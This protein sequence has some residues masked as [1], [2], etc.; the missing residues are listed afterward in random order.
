MR[1]TWLTVSAA[2]AIIFG[3]RALG[4]EPRFSAG[5]KAARAGQ[6]A[7][8]SFVVSG[9]TDVEVAVLDAN[10]RIVRHLAA[11]VLGAKK[12]PPAPLVAGLSQAVLWDGKDDYGV[13]AKGAPFKARVR[14]GLKPTFSHF[15]GESPQSYG[16]PLG[17]GCDAKGRLH[18]MYRWG[19]SSTHYVSMGIKVFD[20]EGK[21]VRR[22]VPYAAN[23]PAEKRS[24]LKWIGPF[25]DGPAVPM[26][27]IGHSRDLYPEIGAG[28]QFANIRHSVL[29]RPDGRLVT[30]T[31]PSRKPSGMKQ[32]RVITF[33]PDGGAGGDFLGPV[34]G[35]DGAVQ[36]ALSPDGK[37]IYLSGAVKKGK[38][39]PAVF[40][41]NWDREGK[42]EVFLGDAAKPGT[43]PGQFIEPRGIAADAQGNIYV[44]DFGSDRVAVFSPDGKPLGQIPVQGADTVLVHPKTGAVYVVGGETTMRKGK[45]IF[46]KP[47]LFKFKDYKSPKVVA[48]IQAGYKYA[49]P[50]ACLDAAA[51]T[52][53]IYLARLKY[54]DWKIH[55]FVD[56]GTSF[57]AQGDPL[58]AAK[59]KGELGTL[60]PDISVD[61]TT[62]E[63]WV[64]DLY[65]RRYSGPVC[66]RYEGASGKYLGITKL[67]VH[68]DEGEGIFSLDGKSILHASAADEHAILRRDGSLIKKVGPLPG[69]HLHSRGAATGPDGSYY[70]LHHRKNRDSMRGVVSQVGADGKILRKQFIE[71]DAPVGGIKVDLQGNVYVG[72]HV[73]PRGQPLPEWL[74]GKL[75]K[76]QAVWYADM[77]GSILKFKPTGGALSFG[78]GNLEG[79]GRLKTLAAKD[80]VWAYYGVA[81]ISS[82]K[83]AGCICQLPRFDVDPWGRVWV[84]EVF[85][86]SVRVLDNSTNPITRFGSYGNEDSRGPGGPVKTPDIPL[87]WAPSVQVTDNYIYI[88]DAMNHRIVVLKPEAAASAECALQ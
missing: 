46:S 50:R 37:T 17:L 81:P 53:I 77:Y 82:R 54:G 28:G 78:E 40:R 80:M 45:K 76:E 25:G 84:P 18:V 72:A 5:P 7:T 23:L 14:L 10:G 70:V 43:G 35:A 68:N 33:G 61:R 32:R 20:R 22:L 2:I 13:K 29:F 9:A 48:Q 62:E 59:A 15:I 65:F 87:G 75:P 88:A 66:K 30:T 73:K 3:S 11:G 6:G 41:T 58:R 31:Y 24:E 52:P 42:P 19:V 69:G 49:V 34:L 36:L 51:D 74:E 4:S 26:V 21:Y 67:R 8:I 83:V 85:R 47:V 79:G 71:V 60:W 16:I 38:P 12:A 39:V 55:K 57:E 56:K 27:H 63:I 44:A 1:G 64:K 86:F